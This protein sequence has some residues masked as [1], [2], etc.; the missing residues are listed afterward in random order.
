MVVGCRWISFSP[1]SLG[2]TNE[3][4]SAD[5]SYFI[6][7]DRLLRPGGY[8]VLSGPPVNFQGKEKEY[9]SL[10][11]L[12]AEKMCYSVVATKDKTAVWQKPTSTTCHL[13]REKQIPPFCAEDDADNAW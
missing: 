11:E 13:S 2:G 8:F 10:Q 3:W 5:G 12:I 1:T 7:I 9:E 6:E 4:L